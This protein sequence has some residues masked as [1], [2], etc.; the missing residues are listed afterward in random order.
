[1]KDFN[2]VTR[3]D[4]IGLDGLEYSMWNI[5]QIEFDLQDEGRT[6]KVYHVDTFKRQ[7]REKLEVVATFVKKLVGDHPSCVHTSLIRHSVQGIEEVSDNELRVMGIPYKFPYSQVGYFFHIANL[8]D[9]ECI[10]A[11]IQPPSRL[12]SANHPSKL[13]SEHPQCVYLLTP[14]TFKELEALIKEAIRQKKVCI[15]APKF[16]D[17]DSPNGEGV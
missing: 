16:L 15:I 5:E 7:D 12:R 14:K 10:S 11:L 9:H 8:S 4:V 1:M 13:S 2:G 6:L 17:E 3:L